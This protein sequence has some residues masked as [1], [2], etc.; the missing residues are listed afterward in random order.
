VG[1]DDFELEPSPH[2]PDEWDPEADQHDPDADGLTIPSVSTAESDAPSEVV[3]T[4]W[5]V[6]LVVN[7]AILF[8]SLGPM[9]IYFEGQVQYGLTL[10][11]GGLVLFGLAYRRYRRFMDAPPDDDPSRNESESEIESG[12]DQPP[13][14]ASSTQDAPSTQTDRP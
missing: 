8:V 11:L 9:L 4:F 3:R 2:E 10:I 5:I 14:D 1:I 6:V 7:V 12:S 13:V